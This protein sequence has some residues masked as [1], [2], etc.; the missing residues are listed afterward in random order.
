MGI[1]VYNLAS[2]YP[3]VSINVKVKDLIEAAKVFAKELVTLSGSK[4]MYGPGT[5][6]TKKEV[7]ELLG[8]SETT[9]WRW[10]V[11]SD[12]LHPVMIGA[13]R[14]WRWKDI[15]AIMEGNVTD[16]YGKPVWAGE[17]M[18]VPAMEGR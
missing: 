5:L 4:V 18:A 16:Y 17:K 14:R 2:D 1:D 15:E 8:V 12:Y 6:L 10:D 13:E 7:M 11:K 3:D 9:L